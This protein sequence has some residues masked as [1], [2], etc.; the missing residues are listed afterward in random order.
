[1]AIAN[2]TEYVTR[3][4]WPAQRLRFTKATPV[5][6][7]GRTMSG[8]LGAGL[9]APGVAPTTAAITDRTTVGGFGQ[10]NASGGT[11]RILRA[12][13]EISGLAPGGFVTICDRL[14]HSGGLSGTVITTQ[15]TNL[16]TPTLTRKTTGVGV[17]MALEIYTAIGT[18]NT[19]TTTVTYKDGA[20]TIQ[21]APTFDFGKANFSTLSRSVHIPLIVGGNS[22]TTL[23]S[24]TI[25]VSTATAGNF[26][27]TL[28]YPL[29]SIPVDYLGPM[30]DD[31]EALYGFGPWFPQVDD[32][33]C[34]Y[35]QYTQNGTAAALIHGELALGED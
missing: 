8:W 6:I 33:A 30:G 22:V 29:V 7:Q 19:G 27:A 10:L 34:V 9:P 20:G 13:F 4:Q 18:S 17:M 16:P 21:T 15:T 23:E 12:L 24:V 11:A 2:E 28:F 26:G 1:M 35:F 31:A 3:K 5:A 14:A 32:D 25:A